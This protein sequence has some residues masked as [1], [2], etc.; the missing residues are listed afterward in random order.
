VEQLEKEGQIRLPLKIQIVN[1]R[2]EEET[3]H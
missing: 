1:T 2:D 3:P